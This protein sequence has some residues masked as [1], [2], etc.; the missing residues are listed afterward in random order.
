MKYVDKYWVYVSSLV[1]EKLNWI[2]TGYNDIR[3]FFWQ[4]VRLPIFIWL[5]ISLF[6][7]FILYMSIMNNNIV[8]FEN[9]ISFIPY[10]LNFETG[11]IVTFGTL[12]LT[13]FINLHVENKSEWVSKHDYIRGF[14]YQRY[15]TLITY[16]LGIIWFIEF[17][18]RV[19]ASID[20]ATLPIQKNLKDNKIWDIDNHGKFFGNEVPGDVPLWAFLFLSWFVISMWFYIYNSK[21]AIHYQVISSYKEISYI[22]S[23]NKMSHNLAKAVVKI[24]SISDIDRH[25]NSKKADWRDSIRS[26]FPGNK[27]SKGSIYYIGK[28]RSEI[29]RDL[30]LFIPIYIVIT[31]FHVLWVICSLNTFYGTKFEIRL[32][33]FFMI[34]FWSIL[35]GGLLIFLGF[36]SGLIQNL[37]MMIDTNIYKKGKLKV[38]YYGVNFYLVSIESIVF[39]PNFIYAIMF[40]EGDSDHKYNEWTMWVSMIIPIILA[41]IAL[42][43]TYICLVSK[44]IQKVTQENVKF[45]YDIYNKYGVDENLF[46]IN[47]F[48][49]ARIVYLEMNV[50]DL[51]REYVTLHKSFDFGRDGV[52]YDYKKDLERAYEIAD[53][54]N[55]E[56]PRSVSFSDVCIMLIK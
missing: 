50:D 34:T 45:I 55:D 7:G 35:M 13:L 40:P 1:G 44:R 43:G 25:K 53:K 54:N 33:N 37:K 24:H 20:L 18:Y 32:G 28:F 11:I 29:M 31:S 47:I 26:I 23:Q 22:S 36:F 48:Y 51:Y 19:W 6:F 10:L 15:V 16:F 14:A 3:K 8:I 39:M 41:I 27:K 46:D 38:F 4:S 12:L 56:F 5:F 52:E 49:I 17:I 42:H 9:I 21:F 30:W 2:S